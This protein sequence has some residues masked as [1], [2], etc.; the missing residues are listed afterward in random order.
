MKQ[1]SAQFLLES[2]SAAGCPNVYWKAVPSCGTS[3]SDEFAI[4]TMMNSRG[5][6][7]DDV[8]QVVRNS[9]AV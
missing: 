1:K 7:R 5:E 4:L 6:S 8:P 3:N 2:W 9:E